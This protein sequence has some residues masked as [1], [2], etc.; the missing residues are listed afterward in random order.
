VVEAAV[1][2]ADAKL[3]E[4]IVVL[5]VAEQLEVVDSFVIVSGR[6]TRQVSTIVEEVEESTKRRTGRA[7]LR[8]EGLREASWVL[9][10]YGDVVVHV[11]L[12]ETRSYYDLEHLWSSAPR[13]ELASLLSPSTARSG[14]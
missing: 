9:M 12:D 4:D 2:A 14:S 10:D 13:L 7:P 5:D 1:V 3:G 6:N 8:I 11:F